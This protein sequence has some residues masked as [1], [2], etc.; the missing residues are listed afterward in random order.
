MVLLLN[1]ES[2]YFWILR[3]HALI[4]HFLKHHGLGVVVW[5][6]ANQR[7]GCEFE[8]RCWGGAYD[9]SLP[10]YGGGSW[11]LVVWVPKKTLGDDISVVFK[12]L[13]VEKCFPLKGGSSSRFIILCLI[14]EVNKMN[15][16][17]I[18]VG[19]FGGRV[20]S[21]SPNF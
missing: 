7:G 17:Y 8:S 15:K 20:F 16:H 13:S 1:F 3:T 21:S 11:D 2:R 19:S 9:H 6:M 10:N 14:G 12:V 18:H 4:N 5:V